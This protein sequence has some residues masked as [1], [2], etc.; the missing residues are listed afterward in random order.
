MGRQMGPIDNKDGPL[1]MGH[2]G[3]EPNI[4]NNAR[5]I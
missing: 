4:R 2:F 3:N 1:G 5:D